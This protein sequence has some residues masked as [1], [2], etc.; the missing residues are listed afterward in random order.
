M[1]TTITKE[2]HDVWVAK[3]HE[4]SPDH[5]VLREFPLEDVKRT[6]ELIGV[7]EGA[8]GD[9]TLRF[10]KGGELC[11][12]CGRQFTVLDLFNTALQVHSKEFLARVIDDNKYS[13]TDNSR[14]PNCYKCGTPG[15]NPP[16]YSN[17]KYS[18]MK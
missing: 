11:A 9:F 6:E 2:E 13:H 1:S 15:P 10:A 8:L 16:S 14:A 12:N 18:C 7:Q 4:E 5:V 17:K 3:I